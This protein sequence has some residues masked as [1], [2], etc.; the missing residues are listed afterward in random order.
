METLVKV[1]RKGQMQTRDWTSPSG[2]NVIIN[3]VELK[4]SNGIDTFICEAT[5][6]LAQQLDKT[7]FQ[8]GQFAMVNCSL[9]VRSWKSQSSGRDVESNSIRLNKI[10]FL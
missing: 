8:E 3:S 5:D 7:A 9:S 2:E 10:V 1:L 4:V 6:K